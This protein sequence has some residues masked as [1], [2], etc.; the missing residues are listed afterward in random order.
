MATMAASICRGIET[1][2][3]NLLVSYRVENSPNPK[4]GAK[5]ATPTSELSLQQEIEKKY[6][7]NTRRITEKNTNFVFFRVSGRGI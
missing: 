2:V 1:C 4:I 7:G 3:E 6:P 5:N